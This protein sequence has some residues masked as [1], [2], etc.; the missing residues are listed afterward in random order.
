MKQ[1]TIIAGLIAIFT[2]S[3]KSENV[4]TS[5]S[6]GPYLLPKND[7]TLI[8]F[9]RKDYS[10]DS[11]L[12]ANPEVSKFEI[13]CAF[14]SINCP[15]LSFHLVP[16][17]VDSSDTFS[18]PDKLLVVSDIEGNY[19][20]YYQLLLSNGVIDSNYNWTFGQGQ[21]VI[22]GDLIDRGNYMTQCLWLTY[23]LE[24]EAQQHGGRVHFLLGNHEQL[25]LLGFNNYNANKY[26]KNYQ[27]MRKDISQLFSRETEIGKWIRKKNAIIKIGDYLFVHGGI[28]PSILANN[29]TLEMMNNEIRRDID[30]RDY[31][32]PESMALLSDD[33]ILWY[34]GL[35]RGNDDDKKIVEEDLDRIL[36]KYKCKSIVVGHSM[37]D[38]ISHDFGGKVIRVDVNHYQNSSA[39]LIENG[40]C[41]KTDLYANRTEIK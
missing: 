22:V 17:K 38:S 24:Y 40:K 16:T 3:C 7:S 10:F 29:L 9:E 35:V 32:T 36:V 25:N 37:V 34:R 21:L 27:K 13:K 26:L 4:V 1:L 14:D 28:S 30:T 18:M 23:H 11:I 6:D 8:I 19:G 41:F 2:Y 39:L 20:K 31:K 12:V 5:F 15:Q 33:G